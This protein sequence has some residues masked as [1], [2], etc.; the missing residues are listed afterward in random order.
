MKEERRIRDRSRK[1]YELF[2]ELNHKYTLKKYDGLR[3]SERLEEPKKEE[4]R[5]TQRVKRNENQIEVID[6]QAEMDFGFF[7]RDV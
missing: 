5:P 2:L 4:L 7:F 3:L 1:K 6:R